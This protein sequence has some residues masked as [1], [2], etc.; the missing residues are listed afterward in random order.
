MNS[1]QPINLT[2]VKCCSFNLHGYRNGLSMLYSLC[3]NHDVILLQEHWLHSFEFDKISLLFPDF[4]FYGASAMNDKVASGLMVGRP[5][6]GVAIM[7]RKSINLCM[8]VIECDEDGRYLALVLYNN[9]INFMFHCVY[10]PCF[11]NNCDYI[12]D[13]SNIISKLDVNISG[14]PNAFHWL[15]GDFNFECKVN[16]KGYDLFKNLIDKL[17]LYNCDILNSSLLDY[18]YR[19]EGLSHK[20]WI[21]HLFVSNNLKASAS[22]FCIIDNGANCSDHLPISCT[23]NTVLLPLSTTTQLN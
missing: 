14:S 7:W 8:K 4:N 11:S 13:V 12:V 3:D 19:H 10:F 1:Q 6:G 15:G 18:T 22:N 20:S 21:D 23:F 9:K 2:D 5:F 17:C 16:V